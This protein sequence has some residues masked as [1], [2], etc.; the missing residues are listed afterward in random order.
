MAGAEVDAVVLSA[1][2]HQALKGVEGGVALVPNHLTPIQ[3]LTCN[4]SAQVCAWSQKWRRWVEGMWEE[5]CSD[6]R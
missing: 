5:H 2:V 4:A 3:L 6:R 1:V